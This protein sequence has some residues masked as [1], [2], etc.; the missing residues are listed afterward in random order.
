[1]TQKRGRGQPGSRGRCDSGRIRATAQE[2]GLQATEISECNQYVRIRV[3]NER[4]G[5]ETELVRRGRNRYKP[6]GP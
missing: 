6:A 5:G 1:M 2:G 3:T 4:N